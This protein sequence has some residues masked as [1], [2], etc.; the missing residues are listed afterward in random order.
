MIMKSNESKLVKCLH[1][2]EM[3][4]SE[5][6]V[7]V[8]CHRVCKNLAKNC[9]SCAEPIFKENLR[10]HFCGTINETPPK[11]P[12][13][14]TRPKPP[15]S[16][17]GPSAP[18]APSRVPRRPSAPPGRASEQILPTPVVSGRG[19]NEGAESVETPTQADD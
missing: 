4:M 5:A 10:C 9:V 18:T 12:D 15:T 1:C 13:G 3:I 6:A 14:D 11:N 19:S 2:A 8:F 7:C 16:G 17:A